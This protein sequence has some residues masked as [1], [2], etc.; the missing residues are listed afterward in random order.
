MLQKPWIL[1]ATG[2][3]INL[4][5]I[6]KMVRVDTITPNYGIVFFHSSSG[7]GASQKVL[8]VDA[9]T[10]DAKFAEIQAIMDAGAVFQDVS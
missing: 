4:N 5:F 7:T 9:A 2:V 10:A 8:Y 1:V 6:I 3:M